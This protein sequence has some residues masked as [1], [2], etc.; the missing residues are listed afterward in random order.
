MIVASAPA[1]SAAF[2]FSSEETA[3]ISWERDRACRRNGELFY[4]PAKTRRR[5]QAISGRPAADALAGCDHLARDLAPGSERPRG[6][7]L[8]FVFNDQYVGIVDRAGAHPD[9]QLARSRRRIGQFVEPQRL[10]ATGLMGK[11]CA[12]Q[13]LLL[14]IPAS[15]VIRRNAPSSFRGLPQRSLPAPVR[16]A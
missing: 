13:R 10:G 8:I 3:S 4:Q 14:V 12:D 16:S 5:D 1:S 2:A 15:E 9:E 6:F 7:Q 11:K